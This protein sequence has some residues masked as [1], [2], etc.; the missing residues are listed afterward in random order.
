MADLN[1]APQARVILWNLGGHPGR[2]VVGIDQLGRSFTSRTAW[3]EQ[4]RHDPF[5]VVIEGARVVTLV[6]LRYP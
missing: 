6:Q 5:R 2:R 3:G 1:V 4:I